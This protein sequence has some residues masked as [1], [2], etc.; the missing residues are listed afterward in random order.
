VLDAAASHLLSDK[1]KVQIS[2]VDMFAFDAVLPKTAV[3]RGHGVFSVCT[4]EAV[5]SFVRNSIDE[6]IYYQAKR[7]KV[8]VPGFPDMKA[9]RQPRC[10]Y[11]D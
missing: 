5:S 8:D 3:M 2:I 9:V 1:E 7:S 10:P 6:E 4:E 11:N